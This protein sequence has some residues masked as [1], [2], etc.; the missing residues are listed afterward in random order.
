LELQVQTSMPKAP[1]FLIEWLP[2]KA[3]Q[4]YNGKSWI[5]RSEKIWTLYIYLAISTPTMKKLFL[6]LLF[7]LS[8]ILSYG[9]IIHG[10]VL[11]QETRKPVDYAS[12]FFNGTFVGTSTNEK[13][14]FE[15]DVT[16]YA[17]RS[18]QISAVGYRSTS[19]RSFKAGEHYTVLLKKDLL[20]IP[21]VSIESES[22]IR[23][24]KRNMRIFKDEFLGQSR[25]AKACVIINEE[26]ITFN[27]QSDRDTL[28]AFARKPLHILNNSL[29]YQITYYLDKFEYDKVHK[30]TSFAGNIIFN[31]DM[32]VNGHMRKEYEARRKKTYYGSCKHFFSALWLNKHSTEGFR[33][34]EVES[35]Y[36]LERNDF[37]F[38]DT[39][40]KKYFTYH[41]NLEIAYDYYLTTVSFRY[42]SVYFGKDGF[43]EPEAILWYGYMS[44]ARIADWLPYE[45]SPGL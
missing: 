32:A 4:A 25:N 44:H 13:G 11:D 35:V 2:A 38:E 3:E 28:G 21:E 10:Q 30:T 8:A 43:F 40:G 33:V 19:L 31:L 42:P 6:L 41:Q 12:V 9:Q 26:D 36:P 18:L 24:R 1:G 22:L 29:G 7:T 27:Y 16:A 5:L 20:E 39:D 17:N 45:Y 15:L 34:Q 37:V 23:A 14:E